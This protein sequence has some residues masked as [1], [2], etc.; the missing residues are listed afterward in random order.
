MNIKNYS[1]TVSVSKTLNEIE[2]LLV[3]HNATDVLKQYNSDKEVTAILFNVQTEHGKASF[4]LGFDWRKVAEI[5]TRQF[6]SRQKRDETRNDRKRANQVL[7][8]IVKDYLATQLSF[9]EIGL[10]EIQQ[11][12]LPFSCTEDGQAFYDIYKKLIE[13]EYKLIKSDKSDNIDFIEVQK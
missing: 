7:W 6:K 12:L 2:E 10:A 9:I 4:K 11:V 1:T 8:R 3:N 13:N 5:L